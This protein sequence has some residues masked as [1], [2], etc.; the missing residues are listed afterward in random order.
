MYMFLF[1]AMAVT[2]IHFTQFKWSSPHMFTAYKFDASK[3]RRATVAPR[4]GYKKYWLN[5][6][7]LRR[8]AVAIPHKSTNS[9]YNRSKLLHS[10]F[11]NENRLRNSVDHLLRTKVEPS[12]NKT[13]HTKLALPPLQGIQHCLFINLDHRQDRLNHFL[14]QLKATGIACER[15]PG[16]NPAKKG[17]PHASLLSACYDQRVCPGQLGCQ[18]SH[19][20]A[21]DLAIA[22]N[23]S[24]VAIFEDDFTFRPSFSSVDMQS[25]VE[26]ITLQVPHWR[27]IGLSLNIGSQTILGEPLKFSSIHP[28]TPLLPTIIHNAQTTGGLLFRDI[29]VLKRYRHL[30]SLEECNVRKDYHT[31]I[32]QC[33]KP[34][35]NEGVWVGLSP[36]IGT[37]MPSF[38][39]IERMNVNYGLA[40]RH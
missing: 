24:H 40:R 27:V 37:Q 20:R 8:A 15:V 22:R 7:K 30:I 11:F 19:L 3:L 32:D 18:L 16:V 29:E 4:H 33:M 1:W 9:E 6:S 23:W 21:V 28:H 38:S 31:A 17:D 35:Q 13:M 34:M 26:S 39:D 12:K 25:L 36:Q 10:G 5:A 14:Q 2:V